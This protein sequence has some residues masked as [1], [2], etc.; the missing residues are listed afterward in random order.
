MGSLLDIE[1]LDC[2]DFTIPE[3]SITM[4]EDSLVPETTGSSLWRRG[5][6]KITVLGK[7][8]HFESS[9][10][11]IDTYRDMVMPIVQASSSNDKTLSSS[12]FV[13]HLLNS[14][15]GD[16]IE[17][18]NQVRKYLS[19][20]DYFGPSKVGHYQTSSFTGHD[21]LMLQP[22]SGYTD[23][24]LINHKV[25]LVRDSFKSGSYYVLGN[26]KWSTTNL[27]W[28]L[29]SKVRSDAI[30]PIS[31][32]FQSW[33]A[34]TNFKFE[35]ID[36]YSV[37][38]VKIRFTLG[39]MFTENPLCVAYSHFPPKG[40]IYFKSSIPWGDGARP[41]KMDIESVALHELGHVL[42][43]NHSNVPTAVMYEFTYLGVTKRNLDDDDIAGINALYNFP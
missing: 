36:N 3:V 40:L 20:Y 42:G 7:L 38:N 10:N 18:L 13:K 16:K 25:K 30:N 34:A 24:T 15:K 23:Q 6:G 11:F 8:D 33:E 12:K 26:T 39:S 41:E 37:A 17:R 22:L 19:K 1:G 35:K 32:A 43:L 21:S 31:S 28:A 4:D 29:D 9:P 14:I 27:T 2:L 5:Q